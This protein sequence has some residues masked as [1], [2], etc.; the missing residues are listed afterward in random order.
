MSVRAAKDDFFI[1]KIFAR[2]ILDS[3]GN[4]TVEVTVFTKTH[5]ATEEVPSGA[6]TGI[7]EAWELRDGGKRYGGK[8]VLKA[9]NNV[10]T[11]INRK[12]KGFDVRE[13]KKI[14]RAL[15]DLDGT[16][17]KSRLG[18]NAIL[19]VSLASYRLCSIVK[20]KKLYSIIGTKNRLPT[21][22]FNVLNGGK[23]AENKLAFQEFMI[24]PK[25]KNFAD[26]VRIG[27]ETYH[28][29]KR[30][31]GHKYGK[32]STNVGDEG[33]FAPRIDCVEQALNLLVTAI[34]D[35]GYSKKIK[36]A[37]DAAASEFFHKGYYKVDGKRFSKNKFV[38]FYEELVK[39]YPIVSIEDP[40]D[41][42]D[43]SGFSMLRQNKV[44]KRKK[45]Q[46]VGDDLLVTSVDRVKLALD[47]NLCNA[48]LLKVNQIGTV[49]EALA[50]AKLALKNDWNVMV[51]HRSGE[52]TS[53]FISDLVVGLGSGQIK[54]GAPCRGE[55][56]AKYNR[57]MQ[58]EV[59]LGKRAKY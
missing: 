38:D 46:I 30:V 13:P 3:R 18:A 39:K 44:L 31:I 48:L 50:A 32:D 26:S 14:D 35:L 53:T 57:L 55:R 43:F 2:E 27:A 19:G 21:P 29:L 36:I 45:V 22:F 1:R 49:T 23:H 11:I 51:S 8:G 58:I 24:A 20:N 52:T 40:F 54:S 9:V 33:G 47:R 59:E 56:L 12:L 28:E 4:P 5:S 10:N 6:S 15:V 17:N 16:K 34:D 7:H 42:D 37:M 41:Q 25:G